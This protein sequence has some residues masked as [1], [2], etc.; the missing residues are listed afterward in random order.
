MHLGH[1]SILCLSVLVAGVVLSPLPRA[2]AQHE[3]GNTSGP[4]KYLVLNNVELKPGQ[5]SAF[6]K[7]ENEEI[8][9]MRAAKAPGSFIGMWSI[10]GNNHVLFTHGFDSFADLQKMH[11]QRAAM[12]KLEETIQVNNAQEGQLEVTR[13]TSIYSFE[14]DLSLN[15]NLDLSKMRFMRIILFH[16]RDGHGDDWQHLVKQVIK[17]YQASLPNARWAMFQKMYGQGSGNT[18]L[19]VT[20]MESLGAVDSMIADGK[21]FREGAGEDWLAMFR[22]GMTAVVDSEETHLFALG[23]KI[24]YVPDSWLTSSPDFWGKK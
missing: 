14:K 6:A 10:T 20:P 22:N 4:S 3:A 18:Y 12:T 23:Q 16:V 19:L 24:S 13:H 11:D 17:T 21:K 1:R 5:G 9:A 2:R 7:L 15:V 8:E